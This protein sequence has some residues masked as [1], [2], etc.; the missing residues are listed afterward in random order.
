MCTSL[1]CMT[2]FDDSI[3]RP[4]EFVSS[5]APPLVFRSIA[6][7]RQLV[8]RQ[9]AE[10][11]LLARLRLLEPPGVSSDIS[12]MV[13]K[14]ASQFGDFHAKADSSSAPASSSRPAQAQPPGP[15]PWN[16]LVSP[17]PTSSPASPSLSPRSSI[18]CDEGDSLFKFDAFDLGRPLFGDDKVGEFAA[19]L[20]NRRSTPPP[21]P[22]L[23]PPPPPPPS[24]PPTRRRRFQR[25]PHRP[26]VPPL[27]PPPCYVE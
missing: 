16:W 8:P 5:S 9:V 3:R 11:K 21:P 13:N 12:M 6:D 20:E 17:E 22:P 24:L 7:P 27:P 19:R 15:S 2:G 14:L 26:P 23:P 4:R 18:D 1:C 25:R 10:R